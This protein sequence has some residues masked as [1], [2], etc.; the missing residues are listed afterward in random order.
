MPTHTFIFMPCREPWP[1]T[2]VD[3]RLPP[4]PVLGR[5]GKPKRINGKLVTIR[6]SRWLA[7]IRLWSR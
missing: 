3:A 2:S 4:V 1:A 7:Q 5:N 6:A